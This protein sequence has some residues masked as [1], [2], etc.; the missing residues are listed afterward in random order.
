MRAKN[1]AKELDN[2]LIWEKKSSSGK[3]GSDRPLSS[4]LSQNVPSFPDKKSFL[5]SNG[6]L[7]RW[8]PLHT[9]SYELTIQWRK[10][11]PICCTISVSIGILTFSKY[12]L[13][14]V[15]FLFYSVWNPKTFL[16]TRMD[17]WNLSISEC[18]SQESHQT[19][20]E[21]F[22][23]VELQ[24]T[25]HL[26]WSQDLDMAELL[27]GGLLAAVFMSLFIEFLLSTMMTEMKCLRKFWM[28]NLFSLK[29][30]VKPWKT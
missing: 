22:P 9:S 30:L 20:L 28:I 2:W 8:R 12:H 21:L 5:P 7:P 13:Q 11:M 14:R 10:N 16:S 24:N 4:L 29:K 19:N 1:D 25:L 15:T 27:I 18:P 23:P 26:K 3:I 6:I 17:T